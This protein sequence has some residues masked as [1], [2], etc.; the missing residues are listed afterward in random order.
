[1]RTTP[2]TVPR[3]LRVEEAAQLLGIGRSLAYDLIRSGQLRSI[4]IG[5]RR[6]IPVDA[7][8]EAIAEFGNAGPL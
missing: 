5:R 1:M 2:S 8:A 3:V 7:I 6:L 4:K